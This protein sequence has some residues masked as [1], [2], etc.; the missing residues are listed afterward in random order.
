MKIKRRPII[1]LTIALLALILGGYLY[2]KERSFSKGILKLE[3]LG[4]EQVEMAEEFEYTVKYKNNSDFTLESPKLTFE[5]PQYS[6][7]EDGKTRISED[8]ENIYPGDEKL[9]HFKA[10]LLGQEGDFKTAKAYLSFKPQNLKARYESNTTYTIKIESVPVSLDFDLPSKIESGKDIEFSINYFL[11][12]DGSLA[13]LRLEAEYPNGF[14]FDSSSPSAL[15][16]KHWDIPFLDKTEGGRVN[17]LGL[18]SGSSGERM[19]FKA[20]LGIWK[21]GEF[22]VLKE[23]SKEVEI[24]D[25]QLYISQQINGSY[26]YIASPGEKLHYEIYFRNMGNTA[27]EDLF[28]INKFNSDI[29]DL[30]TAASD[31]GEVRVQENMIVWDAKRVSSLSYLGSRKEGKVEFDISLKCCISP[32][33]VSLNNVLATNEIRIAETVHRFNTKVNSKLVILQRALYNEEIFGNTGPVPPATGQTSTFT[34]IWQVKNFYNN[35]KNVRVRAVLPEGVTLTGKIAPDSQI[36]NFS[37]DSG[38]R[39]VVWNVAD[40]LAPGTGVLNAPPNI[41]FQVSVTPEAIQR[42]QILTLINS[43]KVTAEDHATGQNLEADFSAADT[44]LPDDVGLSN[45][46]GIV[47]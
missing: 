34:I 46:S 5:F 31:L 22:I 20:R 12:S 37:F 9:V 23:S 6:I 4:P 25:P 14:K 43:A 1:F 18:V 15:D 45:H 2:L 24:I 11:N 21:E 35:A 10:R 28:L 42:G 32:Q 16:Q 29:F 7:T 17:V 38:S 3:I 19:E 27:F 33:E 39:E 30:S 8:L 40:D 47:Q 13:D 36:T 26:N 44:R 41:F